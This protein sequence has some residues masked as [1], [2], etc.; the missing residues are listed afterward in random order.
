MKTFDASPRAA[1]LIESMR[2]IGYSLETAVADVIDNSITAE[3]TD[4]QMFSEFSGRKSAIGIVDN[5]F[6]M[7]EAELQEAMRPGSRSPL[8]ERPNTDLGR[9]GLGLKTASFSQCRRLTVVSRKGGVTSAARWDLDRV[10]ETDKWLVEVPDHTD[11]IPWMDKLP[12]HGTLVVWQKL[13]RL[14]ESKDSESE[15]HF[16]QRLSDV[17]EHLSLVFHRFLT[18][19]PWLSFRVSLSMNY[20]PL[21]P[22]DPFHSRHA[23]TQRDPEERIRIGRSDVVLQA[24]TL[25]HHAKV[26]QK[27]WIEFGGKEGYVKNQGFYVYRENRLIIHGTWFNLARQSELTK[28]SRVRV[29]FSNS[30]DSAWKLD[31]KKASAQLPLPIR[32]HLRGL[33]DRICAGSKRV[34][35]HRGTVRVDETRIPAWRRIQKDG[36]IS[37]RIAADHPVL[38]SFSN[39]LDSGDIQEFERILEF[40]ASAFPVDALFADMGGEAEKI[41]MGAVS[42]ETLRLAVESTYLYLVASASPLAVKAMM[43]AVEPFSSCWEATETLIDQLETERDIDE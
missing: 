36:Q 14:L 41:A 28:L 43:R 15:R 23:A 26:S 22:F 37:Y 33:V 1:L 27:E 7:T 5:G 24:F 40:L 35:Q 29:D 20:R 13:D 6:G 34:Y 16:N 9:F 42:P 39:R 38:Q 19:R 18:G 4:I 11:G 12:E 25:P 17:S 3:A 30:L 10:A 21:K 8:A 31:V 2:D 32:K